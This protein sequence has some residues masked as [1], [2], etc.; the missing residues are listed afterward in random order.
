MTHIIGVTAGQD[1]PLWLDHVSKSWCL[2]VVYMFVSVAELVKV[3][4]V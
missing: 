2:G 4:R 3:A 1:V